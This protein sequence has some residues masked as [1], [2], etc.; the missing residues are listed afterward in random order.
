MIWVYFL[1]ERNGADIKVGRTGKALRGRL[2]GVN[3]DQTTD[4]NYVFLCAVRGEPKDETFVLDYFKQMRISKGTRTEYLQPTDEVSE[5]VNWL[6]SQWFTTVDIDESEVGFPHRD[7]AEWLPNETRRYQRPVIDEYRLVQDY[8]SVPNPLGGTAW[9]WMVNPRASFQDYFTPPEIITAAREAMGDIDLDPA[10][11]YGANRVHQI[12]TW[13]DRTRSAFDNPWF[14]RVWLNPPY[15][16]NGPWFAE[17]LRWY[18]SGDI[19]QLC[20]LSPIWAFNTQVARPVM[21]LCSAMVILSPT[22]KF[23]GNENPDKTGSNLPHAVIYIGDDPNRFM[24][25]FA[26]FGIPAVLPKLELT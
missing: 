24:A 19:T 26:P 21:D 23:W 11:H 2:N 25:V 7:A 15:G 16:E 12:P 3:R 17:I 10:S 8:E 4:D 18:T 20:M 13:Y 5:Y 22:P 14:G 9:A 1:G 6:R